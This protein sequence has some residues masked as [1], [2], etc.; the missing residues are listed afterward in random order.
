MEASTSSPFSCS[1]TPGRSC[2]EGDENDR[3]LLR[4]ESTPS[5]ETPL[6]PCRC[7]D[8]NIYCHGK[9]WQ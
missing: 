8:D 5:A 2:L 9:E 1:E 3:G 7:F 6:E 4:V